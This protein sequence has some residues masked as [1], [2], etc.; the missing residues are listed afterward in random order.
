M[1]KVLMKAISG[2]AAY[3]L[4]QS[5]F[6]KYKFS[7][8]QLMELAGLS[9]A[10]CSARTA[11]AGPILVCAGPGNNGGDGLVAA[12]HLVH[13]GRQVHLFY[14][15]RPNKPLYQDLFESAQLCGVSVV[16]DVTELSQYS[17]IVDAI[18]GFSF[19]PSGGIRAPFDAL[20]SAL[21]ATHVPILSVDVPSGWNVDSGPL[22]AIPCIFSIDFFVENS[23]RR[24]ITKIRSAWSKKFCRNLT[25]S[26]KFSTKPIFDRTD[27]RRKTP[28][29]SFVD[30]NKNSNKPGGKH[31]PLGAET[32]HKKFPRSKLSRWT[33]HTGRFGLRIQPTPST[34]SGR[35]TNCQV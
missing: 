35:R 18:F 28:F 8:S 12:R 11:G 10:I 30:N 5:L 7:V 24:K 4:D 32:V 20:I 25:S 9:V 31:F 1:S 23:F 16:S 33:I 27:F 26:N 29:S 6:T 15:K 13:L 17:Q 21:A 2:K 34:V 19:D 3:N 22:D 14:P